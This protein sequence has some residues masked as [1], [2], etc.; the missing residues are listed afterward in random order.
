MLERLVAELQT[1][2]SKTMEMQ[3]EIAPLIAHSAVEDP[4]AMKA[5]QSLDFVTQHLTALAQ[6]SNTVCLTVPADVTVDTHAVIEQIGIEALAARL[7]GVHIASKIGDEAA[8]DCDF[9]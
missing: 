5:L 9:F 8:G 4:N 2:A 7:S 3:S 1:L 6:F